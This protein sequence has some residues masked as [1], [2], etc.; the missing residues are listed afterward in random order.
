M[1]FKSIKLRFDGYIKSL[2]LLRKTR[3]QVEKLTWLQEAQIEKHEPPSLQ[4]N[5]CK[6]EML[7]RRVLFAE[8]YHLNARNFGSLHEFCKANGMQIKFGIRQKSSAWNMM[9]TD[10]DYS[11][12]KRQISPYRS[13][14]KR[15]SN[16][17]LS[18]FNYC[19]VDLANAALDEYL[20]SIVWKQ[21][22]N[23][24]PE[25]SC[26]QSLIEYALSN[27]RNNFLI[28]M[29]VAMYWVDYWSKLDGIFRYHYVFVFSGS[30]IYARVILDLLKSTGV[31]CFVCESFFTG[32]KYYLEERNSPI[33]NNS[34]IMFENYYRMKVGSQDYKSALIDQIASANEVFEERGKN[35]IQVNEF[36]IP[37]YFKDGRIFSILCQVSNDYSLISGCGSV[38][39]S[40]ETYKSLITSILDSSNSYVIVKCHPWEKHKVPESEFFTFNK[41]NSWISKLTEEK[42]KR[43]IL[44]DHCSMSKLLEVSAAV[45]TICSQAAFEAALQ[46]LK[47]YTIG[48]TFYDRLGFTHPFENVDDAVRHAVSFPEA[49][50]LNFNE[51]I[52]FRQTLA[53]LLRWHFIP[54]RWGTDASE[55]IREALSEF[56]PPASLKPHVNEL[57]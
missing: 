4:I 52:R 36:D 44:I 31:R 45:F 14:L 25:K 3:L 11:L 35:T 37:E 56:T 55:L 32:T 24:L 40:V 6:S 26:R 30:K 54:E 48:G 27:D 53:D 23:E 21:E 46:G 47:T 17:D 57:G 38:L 29:A 33:P 15:R 22:N 2:K 8:N 5:E 39:N 51:Y 20:A 28:F 19:G 10:G 49:N 34:R 12:R 50:K 41:L 18:Q 43:V 1:K 7:G 9:L 16:V 13:K 42:K